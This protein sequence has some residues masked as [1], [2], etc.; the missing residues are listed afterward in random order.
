MNASSKPTNTTKKPH[1]AGVFLCLHF[2]DSNTYYQNEPQ[3][4]LRTTHSPAPDQ[5]C[6]GLR[7][8]GYILNKLQ[9]EKQASEQNH[10]TKKSFARR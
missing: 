7:A 4:L 6:G 5:P 9:L 1:L 3:L 10:G 2:M 8:V